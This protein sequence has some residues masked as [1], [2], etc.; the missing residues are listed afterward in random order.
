[1]RSLT[2]LLIIALS[3]SVG[4]AYDYIC[5]IVD[6]RNYPQPVE[7]SQYIEKYANEYGVPEHIVYATI[8]IESNFKSDAVSSAGAVG[9]MQ[10]TPDTFEWL[11][12]RLKESYEPGMLYDPE[13]NIKYGTYFLSYLYSEFGLWET[14][15][16]AYNAGVA[17]VRDWLENEEY[18]DENGVLKNIPYKETREY[19]IKTEKA[20]KIYERLY[21]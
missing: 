12:M 4:Y 13:T 1:M 19:T 18:A 16:A 11:K 5:N 15:W 6:T 9:L 14:V 10:I 2:V 17:R 8:K 21:Y 3:I 20:S 7:Y